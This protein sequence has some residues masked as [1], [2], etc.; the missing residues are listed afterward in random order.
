MV[1]VHP[2]PMRVPIIDLKTGHPTQAFYDHM[3]RLWMRSGGAGDIN[4][5][6]APA[7]STDNALARYT[8]TI[9]GL[10][11]S[12]VIL[13][14]SDNFTG[15]ASI[16]GL[17][18]DLAVA[19]GGTG[20]STFTD[21]GVLLGSGTGAITATAVLA[22]GEMLVGDG[23][24]D[25]V[26][27]SGAT[28]RTS[29]GVAIGTDVQAF[30][31]DTTKNDVANTFTATQTIT[32]T[33]AGAGVAPILILHRNSAS[34]AVNDLLGDLRFLGESDTSVARIYGRIF[35]RIVDPTNA[36]EDG[37]L[38]FRTM[39]A[40][41]DSERILIRQGLFT[42][43]ATGG[44]QGVDT[45]NASGVFD[46]G[47]L[48]TPY[49]FEALRTGDIDLA[50]LDTKV[51]NL[52]IEEQTE[53]SAVTKTVMVERESVEEIAGKRVVRRKMVAEEQP[54][55]E[56]AVVLDSAG[57]DTGETRQIPVTGPAVVTPA[58]TVTRTHGPARR[59]QTRIARDLEPALYAEDWKAKGHLSALPSEAEWVAAG[60]FSTGDLIQRL[61]ETVEVQAVHIDKLENRL[62]A[63]GL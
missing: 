41:T 3:E 45:I 8:G 42:P 40:G 2:P 62:T 38:T 57:N 61:M 43:S 34:P 26:L 5:S 20:A 60:N 18:T 7:S 59:F 58:K 11:D 32:S 19:E 15:I 27:E 36:S 52:E 4:I 25:P 13:D 14:D 28:L 39:V 21:G 48:L 29:I 10:Q 22:D 54:V 9:G 30:D 56:T 53:Y 23:A 55:T 47:V 51:P 16:S 63:G 31:A 24:T 12:G 50:G 35:G 44:D 37:G 1:K 17:T 46:D 49:V 6:T 33:D